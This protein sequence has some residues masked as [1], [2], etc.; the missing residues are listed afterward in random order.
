MAARSIPQIRDKGA[1]L[2]SLGTEPE[3]IGTV[4]LGVIAGTVPGVRTRTGLFW[5]SA[6]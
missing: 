1:G 5:L 3:Q 6:M 2:D 4:P